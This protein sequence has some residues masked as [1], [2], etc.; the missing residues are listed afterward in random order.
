MEII[1]AFVGAIIGA[2]VSF[3]LA[4]FSNSRNEKKKI[5]TA[6][7]SEIK[8]NIDI[9][10]DILEVN[11]KIEFDAKDE[12]RWEWCDI[13]TMSDLAWA[14]MLSTGTLSHLTQIQIDPLSSAYGMVRR[15]NFAAEKIKA[16]KYQPREGK[17]YNKRVEYALE[18]LEKALAVLG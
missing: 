17:E 7:K 2:L 18:S 1:S 8:L 5:I 11:R 6:I 16:G 12:R 9:A 15:A 13:I 3:A 10:K 14:A 4:E